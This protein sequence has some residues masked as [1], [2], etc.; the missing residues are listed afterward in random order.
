MQY[1]PKMHWL[2]MMCY[3]GNAC[4][5]CFPNGLITSAKWWLP[6]TLLFAGSSWSL[7]V[8]TPQAWTR[9]ASRRCSGYKSCKWACERNNKRLQLGVRTHGPW[10][11]QPLENNKPRWRVVCVFIEGPGRQPCL[12]GTISNFSA[13]ILGVKAERALI[14]HS[15]QSLP[16]Q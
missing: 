2:S 3:L 4:P 1:P 9:V 11:S 15:L 7:L 12:A 13:A 16:P 8:R 10:Q 5:G 6:T 14:L